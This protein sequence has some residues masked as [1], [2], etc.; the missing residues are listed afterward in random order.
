M[1]QTS[2][3]IVSP[4]KDLWIVLPPFV[5]VVIALLFHTQLAAIESKYSWWTWLVLIFAGAIFF[6]VVELEKMLMRKNGF[7]DRNL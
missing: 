7:A 3:W 1:P 2:P 6:L 5:V 4:S